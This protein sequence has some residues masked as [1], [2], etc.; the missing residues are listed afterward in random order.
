MK[1]LNIVS[2]IICA[3]FHLLFSSTAS[4]E[5]TPAAGPALE[6]VVKI[7]PGAA[8]GPIDSYVTAFLEEGAALSINIVSAPDF[9]DEFKPITTSAADFGYNDRVIWLKIPIRNDTPVNV[10]QML[11]LHT[12]FMRDI[13]VYFTA[14]D[15]LEH[16]LSQSLTSKFSTRPVRY[17]QLVA[18]ISA[19]ANTRGDIYVRY[20]SEGNT[21]LPISLETP[22]SFAITTN[23]R[24]TVD[25]AFYGVMTMF[26]M[27]SLLGR[28]FWRNP[29]FIAYSFY[30]AS[31]L[32]YI[33]QRDGYAFQYL[34]PNAP[35]W[36]NFSSL[37]VGSSLPIFAAFFTR[38]YL[39]TNSLHRGIDKI[40]L[41]IIAMQILVVC[42]AGAIGASAA[43]KLAVLTTTLAITVFFGIGLAAYRQ[44]GRRTLFFV[45]GWL[46]ILCASIIMTLVHWAELDVSRAQSLD[47]MRVAMVFDALML[48]LAS[49]VSVVD[50]QRDREKLSRERMKTLSANLRLHSRLGRLEQNYHL[51]Q[52]LAEKTNQRLV[53]TTHDLRQPLY[54]LR[55]SLSEIG[56]G[57]GAPSNAAEIEHS[58]SYIEKLVEAVLGEAME[59][60]ELV[61][62]TDRDGAEILNATKLFTS[63][64]TMF[65]AD[66]DKNDV[67]LQ[68]VTSSLSVRAAPFPVLRIMSNFVSN[69]IRYAPGSRV[70]IGARRCG[71][72]LSLEVHDT[73]PG[74]DEAELD[75]V[76]LRF[77]R[78][79]SAAG[80]DSGAGLGL[81]IVGAL[82]KEHGL[83]WTIKSRKGRGSIAKLYVPL[84]DD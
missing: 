15:G 69:A 20:H 35:V 18:P 83:E 28:M 74:M 48:G 65:R 75:A 61:A 56:A 44:Y 4:A 49:V 67:D 73:G 52:A 72:R 51:A 37:P 10:E 41:T 57:D 84:A 31:V 40:L 38:A 43:K 1:V 46:G 34:W 14:G 80:D 54:A 50:I 70:R 16:V 55:A 29:T 63:L 42:S 76:K 3:A 17:H 64:L 62:S 66:A 8:V 13:D 2:A 71:D 53:D 33:F 58:L 82:A 23:A 25:Y 7:A 77:R 11:V 5:P 36:N 30:A 32:L 39:K 9:A 21:V 6:R 26:I 81:S 19:P 47:I 59:E 79:D 45:I 22:L 78:G 68:I 12:N 24:V 60:N 27:A